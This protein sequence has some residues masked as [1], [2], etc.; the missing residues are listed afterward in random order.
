MKI[1]MLASEA[2]PFAKTGGLADVIGALPLVLEDDGQEVIVIMP[3]YKCVAEGKFKV[4]RVCPD[5]S[6]ATIG[7]KVKVYFLENDTYFNRDGLY[8]GKDGDYKDNLERFSFFCRRGLDLLKELDFRADILHL[9]D[10]QASLAAVYLKNS[11][12]EDKF[13]SGMKSVLTIHNLGYQGLFP[14]SEFCKL[15]LK[16]ELFSP[17]GIEFYGQ[18]NLLKGG[19][20]FSDFINTVSPTYARQIQ[21]SELGFGLEGLLR[22]RSDVLSGIVNGLDYYVWDPDT[23]RMILQNFSLRNIEDKVFNKENLQQSCGLTVDKDIP[24]FGIVSRIVEAKGFDILAQALEELCKMNAQLVVLGTGDKKYHEIL[25]SARKKYPRQISLNLRFDD[26]LAHK[27]YAGSDIFLMLSRYEPCG[28]GQLISL[29]YGTIPLVFKTGGL[30]DTINK[31]NG[32][33]F[34]EYSGDSFIEL[35]RKAL[36]VFKDKRKWNRLMVNAMK[37]NFSWE[38]SAKKY[39]QLYAQAKDS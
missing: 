30:A 9:H 31:N 11:Y 15:G 13:Y 10:W 12:R 34:S 2:V 5:V 36:G 37:C 6:A 1:A 8:V 24:L 21:E 28:L 19:I 14:G 38:A 35:A 16:N 23:D 7:K 20:I 39:I 32:F 25:E 18:V 4:S 29:H 27:I 26:P 17:S 33:S 22:R 3:G